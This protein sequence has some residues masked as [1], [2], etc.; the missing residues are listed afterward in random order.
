MELSFIAE[1]EAVSI[2]EQ[3][4]QGSRIGQMPNLRYM[5]SGAQHLQQHKRF[6]ALLDV[7]APSEI[8]QRTPAWHV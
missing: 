2:S 8:P 7:G 6:T 1:D 3:R 4:P 5:S